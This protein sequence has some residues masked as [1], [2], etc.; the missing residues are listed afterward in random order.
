[1]SFKSLLAVLFLVLSISIYFATSIN[2]REVRKQHQE[3]MC[4]V[5]KTNLNIK[6]MSMFDNEY[7]SI[8]K[9]IMYQDSIRK[10][11]TT[12]AVIKDIESA[13]CQFELDKLQ[14]E[15]NKENK[16]FAPA[17]KQDVN[18]NCLYIISVILFCFGVSFLR[19][20]EFM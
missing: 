3:N 7:E 16:D 1:M 9:I 8:Y 10:Q 6:P 17:T 19:N 14:E 12:N 18:D 15:L 2:S 5:G 13:R 11:N 20:N 4:T